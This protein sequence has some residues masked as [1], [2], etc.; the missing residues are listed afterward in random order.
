MKKITLSLLSLFSLAT[1]FGQTFSTGN[2]QL[3]PEYTVKIDITSTLV[4]L[5]QIMPNNK[6]YALAFDNGGAMGGGDIIVFTNTANISDRQLAGYQVPIADAVQSWTTISN[7]EVGTTRTVVSTRALNTGETGDYVFSAAAGSINLACARA[8]SASFVLAAHGA[9]AN[10]VVTAPY[11]ITAVAL[12]NENFDISSFKLSPNP[13]KGFTSIQLPSNVNE[14][15]VKI[16][17]N[18]G[19]LV[20]NKS[21]TTSENNLDTSDLATGSY[22]VVVRTD[23]GNATKT[24]LIE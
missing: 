19:R 6:W 2:I 17:D 4:T 11:A 5:T 9:L 8:S 14:A 3:F 18:L 22:L 12:A 24:L 7:T 10:A 1:T 15:Q 16:Y 23:Y 13:A 21:I 20:R